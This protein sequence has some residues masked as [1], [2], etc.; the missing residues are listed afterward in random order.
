LGNGG[1]GVGKFLAIQVHVITFAAFIIEANNALAIADKDHPCSVGGTGV[2]TFQ[3]TNC[4]MLPSGDTL[5]CSVILIAFMLS[6]MPT[7]F[8]VVKFANSL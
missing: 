6:I 4:V 8:R 7:F 1:E 5:L 2:G 3:I